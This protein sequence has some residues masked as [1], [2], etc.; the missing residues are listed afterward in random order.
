[1]K[2]SVG[3]ERVSDGELQRVCAW[4]STH[5][6]NVSQDLTL[7][8]SKG[9][10]KTPNLFH[11]SQNGEDLDAHLSL[12]EELENYTAFSSTNLPS[13]SH[14]QILP[15]IIRRQHVRSNVAQTA[16]KLLR[17]DLNFLSV[18]TPLQNVAEH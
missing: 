4:S 15:R 5:G 17:I 14:S 8:L 13:L 7:I 2:R 11:L 1:M 3:G 6:T 9:E 18:E 16:Q 12:F 10:G